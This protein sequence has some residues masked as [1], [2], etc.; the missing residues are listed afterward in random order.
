MQMKSNGE[1]LAKSQVKAIWQGKMAACT[2]VEE[3]EQIWH[4]LATEKLLGFCHILCRNMC[5][6][7]A[8]LPAQWALGLALFYFSLDRSDLKQGPY[9]GLVWRARQHFYLL[10]IYDFISLECACYDGSILTTFCVKHFNEVRD[11]KQIANICP[12]LAS[13][14]AQGTLH[15]SLLYRH[16]MWLSACS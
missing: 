9:G 2:L 8:P 12:T 14:I 5:C 4:K 3:I 6:M 11:A 16:F 7:R 1:I 10:L 13:G 15:H